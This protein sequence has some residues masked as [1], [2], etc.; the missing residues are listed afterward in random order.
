M[1]LLYFLKKNKYQIIKF[2]IVGVTSSVLNFLIYSSI[3]LF[4]LNINIA[5]CLGYL[6]GLFNSFLFSKKWVFKSSNRSKLKKQVYFFVLIYIIGGVE[7]TVII[8]IFNNIV[9]NYKIAWVFGAFIA[10]LSNYFGLKFFV[11]KH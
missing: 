10:A 3:Y 6:G 4:T 11:F 2:F 1:N 9:D 5:S 8:N 7:M